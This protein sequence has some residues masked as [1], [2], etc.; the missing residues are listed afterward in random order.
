MACI[1][2]TT[3]K[4]DTFNSV[5]ETLE[6]KPIKNLKKTELAELLNSSVSAVDSFLLLHYQLTFTE[7]IYENL[8]ECSTR[9]PEISKLNMGKLLAETIH[10][11]YSDDGAIPFKITWSSLVKYLKPYGMNYSYSTIRN[12]FENALHRDISILNSLQH[13]EFIDT[14][15]KIDLDCFE[16]RNHVGLYEFINTN[17]QLH[18]SVD[19]TDFKIIHANT[20][21]PCGH[22]INLVYL[23]GMTVNAVRLALNVEPSKLPLPL[24]SKYAQARGVDFVL[25]DRKTLELKVDIKS[26]YAKNSSYKNADY[27]LCWKTDMTPI[28]IDLFKEQNGVSE[29]F[30]LSL[31]WEVYGLTEQMK[32]YLNVS[33]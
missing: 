28:E 10:K 16:K 26:H 30:E 1:G 20:D 14:Y 17:K 27:V 8:E 24:N 9:S 32:P 33:N 12:K 25:F 22:E 7:F 11:Y 31:I 23:Y 3:V 15:Q 4:I 5:I 6:L 13:S 18:N 21:I 29:V 2:E 19:E